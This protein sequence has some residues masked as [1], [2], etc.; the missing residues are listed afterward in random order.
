MT[1]YEYN[2]DMGQF[3]DIQEITQ[4][5]QYFGRASD[6]LE[7]LVEQLSNFDDDLADQYLSGVEPWEVDR[8]LIERAIKVSLKE[9]KAVGLFCGSALKNKGV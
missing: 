1:L 6:Y 9:Q 3:V 8:D 2:D 4:D 7:K 5:H